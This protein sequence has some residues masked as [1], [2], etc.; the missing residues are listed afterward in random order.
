MVS[1]VVGSTVLLYLPP[2]PALKTEAEAE[3]ETAHPP[4]TS[5]LVESK[6]CV[7]KQSYDRKTY[8]PIPI[9]Y[10]KCYH[11]VTNRTTR[12][13]GDRGSVVAGVVGG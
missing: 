2:T 1:V 11:R 13:L 5:L 6:V 10:G 12:R 3:A 8:L 7:K 9:S 4:A